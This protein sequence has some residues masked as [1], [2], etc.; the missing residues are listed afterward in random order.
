VSDGE[1]TSR[2]G[3]GGVQLSNISAPPQAIPVPEDDIV[4]PYHQSSSISEIK[5]KLFQLI[6]SRNSLSSGGPAGGAMGS[7]DVETSFILEALQLVSL[8]LYYTVA[9]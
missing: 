3:T 2:G 1:D 7:S 4:Q 8:L 5:A 6:E 9:V